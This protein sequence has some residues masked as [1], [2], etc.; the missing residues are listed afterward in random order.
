MC[1]NKNQK[2]KNVKKNKKNWPILSLRLKVAHEGILS[3][4]NWI[5]LG[6]MQIFVQTLWDRNC[7]VYHEWETNKFL[8]DQINVNQMYLKIHSR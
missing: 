8:Y 6:F 3:L 1:S 4:H 7:I 5:I 2:D